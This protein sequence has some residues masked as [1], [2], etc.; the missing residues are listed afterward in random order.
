MWY[1]YFLELSNG[2]V[3]VG[4]TNDL[5]RR[6]A[7]HQQGHVISTRG[8]LPV[9]LRSYVAVADEQTARALERYFKSGSGKAF[10]NKRFLRKADTSTG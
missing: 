1:V 7:S 2:D 4:S 10:A 5:R 3:Y 8:L 6:I 9:V